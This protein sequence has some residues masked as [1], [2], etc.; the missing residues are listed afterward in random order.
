M[1]EQE[2]LMSEN[3]FNRL[4]KIVLSEIK[5]IKDEEFRDDVE[6]QW[7]AMTY[8]VFINEKLEIY[9]HNRWLMSFKPIKDRPNKRIIFKNYTLFSKLVHR[10]GFDNDY[11]IGLDKN[12]KASYEQLI[13]EA[14]IKR[15]PIKDQDDRPKSEQ[16]WCLYTKDNSRLLGRHKTLDEAKAQEKA[17]Q[18]SKH[19][20][21]TMLKKIADEIILSSIFSNIVEFFD[22]IKDKK[23]D[24]LTFEQIRNLLAF[25][26]MKQGLQNIRVLKIFKGD[27]QEFKTK[28]DYLVKLK[29]FGYA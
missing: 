15:C 26:F 20:G 5:N 19:G 3:E 21:V 27:D 16:K 2:L 12:K 8:D 18:V 4:K 22:R 7:N 28:E 11:L 10:D 1:P 25:E 6:K 14:I 24:E 23:L 29:G 9:T 17:I 13:K